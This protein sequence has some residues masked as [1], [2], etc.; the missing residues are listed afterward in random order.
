MLSSDLRTK[1]PSDRAASNSSW[2]WILRISLAALTGPPHQQSCRLLCWFENVDIVTNLYTGNQQIEV[3]AQQYMNI[4]IP[5]PE[6]PIVG[7]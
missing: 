6:L 2:C 7:R 1:R 3:V 4:A 5:R